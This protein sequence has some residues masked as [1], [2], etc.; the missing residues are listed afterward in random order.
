MTGSRS[1]STTPAGSR[2]RV[3]R[4]VPV[5]VLGIASLLAACGSSPEPTQ[6]APT[7]TAAPEITTSS[8]VSPATVTPSSTASSSPTPPSARTRTGKDVPVGLHDRTPPGQRVDSFATL[9]GGD[10]L[11]A[12]TSD[13]KPCAPALVRISADGRTTTLGEGYNPSVN[14]AGTLAVASAPDDPSATTCNARGLTVVDLAAGAAIRTS[15]INAAGPLLVATFARSDPAVF[16]IA[17]DFN[18]F[19]TAG[20]L[21]VWRFADAAAQ[22]TEVQVPQAVIAAL[23]SALNP[24]RENTW[25][26]VCAIDDGNHG[27]RVRMRSDSSPERTSTA[28]YDLA[29]NTVRAD[30]LHTNAALDAEPCVG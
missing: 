12:L 24:P 1:D 17:T 20:V 16:A 19:E 13:Q 8:A 14:R 2:A 18:Q 9:A 11:V 27:Y 3:H 25:Y 21:Y 7:S 30:D 23:D 5:V 26:I 6:S 15:R 4:L 22:L 29:T 28:I 10:W